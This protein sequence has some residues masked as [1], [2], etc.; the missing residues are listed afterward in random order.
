MFLSCK[1]S[2][3]DLSQRLDAMQLQEVNNYSVPDYLAVD[4]QQRLNDSSEL[5]INSTTDG[6]ASSLSFSDKVSS[7]QINELWR[8][9]ICEWYYQIVD[10]YGTTGSMCSLCFMIHGSL[11]TR[12]SLFLMLHST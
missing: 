6:V 3:A 2:V 8:E 12:C 10:H 5:G 4:W 9:K 7:S 1:G 11:F